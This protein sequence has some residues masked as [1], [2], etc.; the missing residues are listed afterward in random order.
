MSKPF[1]FKQFIINQDQCAM[2][3]GTDGVL[4]GAWATIE[5]KPNSVLDIGA[6]TGV[7]ALMVAQRSP[8][9]CIDA[10]EI[11]D[12]A[13]E[14]CVANFENSPWSNRLFC[15]HASLE[16]FTGEVDDTYDLIISNPPFYTDD[17]K[18]KDQ[19]R[20]LARFADVLPFEHLLKSASKLLSEDGKFAV[21]IPY[22]EENHFMDLAFT[23]NLF[24]IRILRVKGNPSS[25][26]KR[27]LLEFSF[28]ESVIKTEELIIETERHHYTQDYI[29][30]TK[31]FYLKM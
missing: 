6:G 8:S 5:H 7:I 11:D 2:K 27:S 17:Y 12:K 4:L 19:Q 22:K 24:P 28:H 31:E 20:D 26:M 23:A 16:E 14:Q 21:I 13:F 25:E 1:Q 10:I 18:S 3:I 29:N 30:L 15:Y 9:D